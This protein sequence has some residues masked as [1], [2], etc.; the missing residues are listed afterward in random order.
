MIDKDLSHSKIMSFV[1]RLVPSGLAEVGSIV[2]DAEYMDQSITIATL[3]I[4]TIKSHN[5]FPFIFK[6]VL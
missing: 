4:S 3:V 6:Y 2:R 5:M 1:G